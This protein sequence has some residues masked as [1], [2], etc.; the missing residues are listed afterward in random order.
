VAE[1][2]PVSYEVKQTPAEEGGYYRVPEVQET[3]VYSAFEI[4]Q[5][6]MPLTRKPFDEDTF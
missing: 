5:S 3:P 4:M 1:V 2:K 6:R